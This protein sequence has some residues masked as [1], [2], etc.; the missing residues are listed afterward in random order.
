LKDPEVKA[1]PKR[2]RNIVRRTDK[3]SVILYL[4]LRKRFFLTLGL[5]FPYDADDADVQVVPAPTGPM[6]IADLLPMKLK[7]SLIVR[8]R[9]ENYLPARGEPSHI[10]F[11][12]LLLNSPN[13]EFE[14]LE[15]GRKLYRGTTPYKENFVVII[16]EKAQ[17]IEFGIQEKGVRL[18][19]YGDKEAYS[20]KAVGINSEILETKEFEANGDEWL[21]YQ[22]PLLEV[23]I[24]K[25]GERKE[26]SISIPLGLKASSGSTPL[27]LKAFS[28]SL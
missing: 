3:S 23:F 2:F 25:G 10:A 12:L 13:Y 8:V 15:D 26:T 1:K 24:K 4:P 28:G 18:E 7:G 19:R 11:S 27:T 17:T 9:E 20:L 5:P 21:Y 22:A 6:V 16:D 14:E